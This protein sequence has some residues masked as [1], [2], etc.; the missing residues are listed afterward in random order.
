MNEDT[1]KPRERIETPRNGE[2]W[3][4]V[5][6]NGGVGTSSWRCRRRNRM[7]NCQNA[8]CEG[9]NIW[10]VSNIYRYRYIYRHID[11]DR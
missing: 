3:H 7:R 10:I 4:G 11:I 2:A 6:R 9:D 1:L 8:E 5:D